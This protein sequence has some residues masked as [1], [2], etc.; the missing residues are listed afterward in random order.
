MEKNI[1]HNINNRQHLR[2]HCINVTDA[3]IQFYMASFLLSLFPQFCVS[4]NFFVHGKEEKKQ[5][6]KI[7]VANILLVYHLIPFQVRRNPLVLNIFWAIFFF[8][9][10]LTPMVSFAGLRIGFFFWL[11]SVCFELL[12]QQRTFS[13]TEVYFI[14]YKYLAS[15][16]KMIP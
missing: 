1:I 11:V 2:S 16:M 14:C 8:S 15:M 7:Q 6:K 5:R 3:W 10:S 9:L 4:K 13:N 12:M